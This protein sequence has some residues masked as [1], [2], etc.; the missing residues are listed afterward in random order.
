MAISISQFLTAGYALLTGNQTIDGT[1]TFSSRSAHAG[2]YTPSSQPTH[3][4]TPTFDCS[5]S[6]VFE[7]AVMTSNVTSI[8][9]S[10]AVAGQTVQIRFQQDG[11]GG[12]T[13]AVPTG[14]KVDGSY[15]LSTGRVNW[16][17]LTYSGR[18][19]R[20]EGNWLQVPA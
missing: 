7:P 4:A 10:N 6:N 12:R 20:W 15:N 2:A 17:I 13:I 11:T 19:S 16:L 18:A 1:K 8:T 5:V 3:S 9:L 14:A